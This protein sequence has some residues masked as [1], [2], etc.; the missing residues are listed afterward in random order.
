MSREPRPNP[1]APLAALLTA[2]LLGGCSSLGS[3]VLSAGA[4]ESGDAAYATSPANIA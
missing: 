3:N 4:P 2:A 1:R